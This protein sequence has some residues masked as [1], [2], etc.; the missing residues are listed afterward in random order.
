[1]TVNSKAPSPLDQAVSEASNPERLDVDASLIGLKREAVLGLSMALRLRWFHLQQVRHPRLL[2][3]FQDL[4]ELMEP[5]NDVN[6]VS[7]VGMTGV[8]KTT[9]ARQ[10]VPHIVSL[11]GDAPPNEIPVLYVK[12]PANG[13]RSL[14]WRV[15]YQRICNAAQEIMLQNRINVDTSTPGEMRYTGR[16]GRSIAAMREVLEPIIEHRNVRM[17]I[18]DEAVHLLR[19]QEYKEVMDTVKSLS[20]IGNMK[21]LLIGSYDIVELMS[22]YGQVARRSEIV[23]YRR[24]SVEQTK[25]VVKDGVEK[26][27]ADQMEF[28]KVLKQFEEIWPSKNVPNLQLAWFEWMLQTLG[29]IGLLKLIR[30]A[31]L[32]LKAPGEKLKVPMLKKIFKTKKALQLLEEETSKGEDA[33]RGGCYG[34]SPFDDD[35]L[36]ALFS[37]MTGEKIVKPTKEGAD[38]VA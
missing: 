33:L 23:H 5:N 1:M 16:A 38:A 7:L 15:L 13:E 14:S 19:F 21:L 37:T 20:D 3:V 2:H 9:L 12:V 25:P 31:A 6:I 11:Y 36:A 18:L 32:Q 8:G 10:L 34:E 29:C 26:L 4:S 22:S 30:L 35:A 17:L 24:Y 28:R 27:T